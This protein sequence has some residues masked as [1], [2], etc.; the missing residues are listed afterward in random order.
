MDS[1]NVA[2]GIAVQDSLVFLAYGYKE[3]F[4]VNARQPENMKVVGVLE[5][6]QPGYGYDLMVQ[7]SLVYIAAG[8]QFILVNVA[9]PRYPNLKFQHYYPR[10]CRGVAIESRYG[11]LACEQLG[12]AVWKLDTF[13]LSQIGDFDTP[14]NARAVAVKDGIL[15]VAD[16]R[17]GLVLVD[18]DDPRD[19]KELA[20]LSL[21]GYASSVTVEDSLVFVACGS[22]GVAVVNCAQPDTPLL[23]AQIKT[24]YAY[25]IAPGPGERYF[26]GL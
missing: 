16:G 3:L 20:T 23:V 15:Y 4:I 18:A 11:F 26:F 12:V 9:D 5:Y 21:D 1:L 22:E 17:N 24:P 14:G 13:P 7:D 8:A 2:W 19:M 10:D 6:P 25:A